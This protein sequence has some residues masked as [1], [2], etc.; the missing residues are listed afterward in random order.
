MVPSEDI[1]FD[2]RGLWS[3]EG[4]CRIRIF[5]PEGFPPVVVA[6]EL[7]ENDNASITDIAGP[8]AADVLRECL[9]ERIGQNPPF[10]WIEHYPG[11]PD[12]P[13]RYSLVTFSR[14]V[15]EHGMNGGRWRASLGTPSWHPLSL[16]Q[17]TALIGEQP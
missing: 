11:S 10:L 2:Y 5:R 16:D 13:G 12:Q 4:V 17:L 9:P 15:P 1:R 3:D 6:T 14:T 7:P 8:L